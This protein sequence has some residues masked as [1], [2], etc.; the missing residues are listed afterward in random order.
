[1]MTVDKGISYSK[2]DRLLAT[3][4]R[5]LVALRDSSPDN[6]DHL[7]RELLRTLI[8]GEALVTPASYSGAVEGVLQRPNAHYHRRSAV[9]LAG[10]P[11]P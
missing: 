9:R 4:L 1:M 5:R 10:G 3:A 6:A 8:I 7:R 2:P 11:K